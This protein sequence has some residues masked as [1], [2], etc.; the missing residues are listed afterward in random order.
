MDIFGGDLVFGGCGNQ[1]IGGV[2]QDLLR[3]LFVAAAWEFRKRLALSVN[4]VNQFWNV[5]T[6]V[7]VEPAMDIGDSDNFIACLMHQNR[8][9]RADVA[10]TLNDH[11]ATVALHLE[12]QI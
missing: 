3:R 12:F 5:E 8:G 6:F 4:P 2:E 7:V 10:E 11:T 1:N 9:L